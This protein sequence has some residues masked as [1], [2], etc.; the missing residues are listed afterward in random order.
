MTSKQLHGFSDASEAAYSAVVYLRTVDTEGNIKTSLVSSKTKV[1]PI[2][3][4]TIPWLELCG[5]LLLAKLL[6]HITR[7]LEILMIDLYAWTDSTIVL[8][9]LTGSPCR[10][11]TF[12]GNRVSQIVDLLPPDRWRHVIGIENPADCAS[13]GLFPSELINHHLWWSGP[14]WLRSSSDQWPRKLQLP[15]D[16]EPTTELCHLTNTS[17]S[18][19]VLII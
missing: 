9:W 17:G 1:S 7:I 16:C 2:K 8:S 15:F 5:A 18:A 10:F 13:R 11:K 19:I 12:V 4:Q 14:D 6:N 3:R